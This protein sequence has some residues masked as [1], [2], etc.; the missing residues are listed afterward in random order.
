M[1]WCVQC[2]LQMGFTPILCDCD[3]WFNS[4]TNCNHTMWTQSLNHKQHSIFWYKK[5][6]LHIAPCKRAFNE[7]SNLNPLHCHLTTVTFIFPTR[8]HV[9]MCHTVEHMTLHEVTAIHWHGCLYWESF[10]DITSGLVAVCA[11]S[12][13]YTWCKA[14]N[15]VF[16]LADT[17]QTPTLTK[18]G[19][20]VINGNLWLSL[21][22]CSVNSSANYN[23]TH[24]LSVSVSESVSG[25]V[26][27]P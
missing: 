27:T 10:G 13:E 23:W 19:S 12:Q 22:L 20:I 9:F 5:M 6:Q 17:I 8:K 2:H 7:E 16:T 11:D 25:S 24:F 4:S 3:V 15:G 14:L 18:M 26:N 1:Y 21:S